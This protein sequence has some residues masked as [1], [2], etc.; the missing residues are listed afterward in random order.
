MAAWKK[1]YPPRTKLSVMKENMR[2]ID[3]LDEKIDQVYK[4]ELIRQQDPKFQ[5]AIRNKPE[6]DP[7]KADKVR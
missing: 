1:A 3:D 4:D 7:V 5:E 2:I 6:P